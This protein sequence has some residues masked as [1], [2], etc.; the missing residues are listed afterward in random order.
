MG[1]LSKQL[2][3]RKLTEQQ[4]QSYLQAMAIQPY[5]PKTT[6]PGAK[7]SPSYD[8]RPASISSA[9]DS[10]IA[11]V[12]DQAPST[13]Q[14]QRQKIDLPAAPSRTKPV[15]RDTTIQAAQVGQ[16]S[17]VTDLQGATGATPLRFKLR[18][19]TI[20][21]TLAVVDEVPFLQSAADNDL[22]L[23]L[24]QS[25]LRALQVP[26]VDG[27]WQAEPF[28]WPLTG[29]K[30]LPGSDA[31]LARQA[32]N[33]FIRRRFER[34]DFKYLL[35]FSNQLDEVITPVELP[36][37]STHFVYPQLGFQVTLT[38]S[39]HAMLSV[40]ALKRTVWHDLQPVRKALAASANDQS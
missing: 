33:G 13:G 4:R 24:L 31:G 10:V 19:F 38:R 7:A 11:R 6:L 30:L 39:L 26:S 35:V 40:P 14:Y 23:R 37:N 32:V 20:N 36:D 18:Y 12:A 28:D 16:S 8:L 29:A 5:F 2:A 21:P 34:H 1:L 9:V 17:P 25:I 15:V 22:S 3:A 27:A